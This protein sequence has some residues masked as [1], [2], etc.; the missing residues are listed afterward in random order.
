MSARIF[1]HCHDDKTLAALDPHDTP[2]MNYRW[3][4]YI[5]FASDIEI[6]RRRLHYNCSYFGLLSWRLQT[7]T[8]Q[9]ASEV[10]AKIESSNDNPDY[11]WVPFTG[12]Q[13]RIN[14][15]MQG[16]MCEPGLYV[17][18]QE[19]FDRCGWDRK[20]MEYETPAIFSMFFIPKSEH[21]EKYVIQYLQKAVIAMHDPDFDAR[22]TQ[23]LRHSSQMTGSDLVKTFGLP[24]FTYH[25]AILERVFPAV[26]AMENWKGMEI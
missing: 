21:Y 10:A 11:W 19:L 24:A 20:Y 8:G 7:K 15:W 26:A 1:V 5:S 6:V 17:L 22:L 13:K 16:E 9:R 2:W 25:S 12:M 14:V 23:P 18:S 3:T 4:K